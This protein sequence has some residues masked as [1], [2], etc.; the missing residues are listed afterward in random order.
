MNVF[1]Q[2][3]E[4]KPQLGFAVSAAGLASGL[5]TWLQYLT[6]I[7]GFAGAVFGCAAGIL[8]FAIKLREWRRG[9]ETI[10]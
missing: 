4:Q 6:P 7:V 8:T 9:R 10:R 2:L 3:L 1:T 5:L